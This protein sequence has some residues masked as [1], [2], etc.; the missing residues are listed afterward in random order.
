MTQNNWNEGQAG[1]PPA[2][3]AIAGRFA[4]L[5]GTPIPSADE[6][7][8]GV[9]AQSTMRG[10]SPVLDPSADRGGITQYRF[11]AA[12]A[13][14][15]LVAI[16]AVA[17]SSRGDSVETDEVAGEA[18]VESQAGDDGEAELASQVADE[19]ETAGMDEG[20]DDDAMSDD[21]DDE[22][23]DATGDDT[24]DDQ[25]NVMVVDDDD[26]QGDDEDVEAEDSQDETTTTIEQG[27]DNNDDSGADSESDDDD[28]TDEQVEE[29]ADELP[30][31]TT[32]PSDDEQGG[33][34]AA[35]TRIS[36]V[37]TE[38]MTD[39]A[40]HLVLGADGSVE[41]AGAVT[42]DGGSF[43]IINGT[44]IYTSSGYVPA[45]LA[46]DKHSSKLRPGMSATV[47]AAPITDGGPLG[48]RCDACSLQIG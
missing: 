30:P 12:A 6:V 39:C 20:P 35:T 17:L 11:L 9:D 47:I 7:L 38:V 42:C 3:P 28:G 27:D 1:E 4:E 8:A 36:G 10:G 24:D 34:S 13:A 32:E 5:E 48:L 15:V 29:P 2:D 46:F 37:V 45:E 22:A 25:D 16:A 23:G 33:E 41:N 21:P 43:V 31:P 26:G 19:D 18:T 14:V 44:R 40:S